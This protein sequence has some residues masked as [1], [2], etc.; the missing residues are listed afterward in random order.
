[1]IQRYTYFEKIKKKYGFKMISMH[2]V[3]VSQN[4]NR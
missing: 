3:K 1:M 4:I 2:F